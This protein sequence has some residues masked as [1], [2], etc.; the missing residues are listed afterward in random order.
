MKKALH[1]NH[2]F[3]EDNDISMV[4]KFQQSES[5]YV[6][7]ME[8]LRNTSNHRTRWEQNLQTNTK[9]KVR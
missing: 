3:A 2:D 6:H 4:M 9:D 8:L 5:K 1:H 7:G